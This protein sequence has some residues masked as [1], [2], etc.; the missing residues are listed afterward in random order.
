[1]EF[2]QKRIFLRD[3]CFVDDTRNPII[4]GTVEVFNENVCCHSYACA[5]MYTY[6]DVRMYITIPN[7]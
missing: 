1:M 4:I 7:V 3:L 2:S 6:I 5:Y